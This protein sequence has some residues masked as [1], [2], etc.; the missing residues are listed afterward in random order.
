MYLCVEALGAVLCGGGGVKRC[1]SCAD[2]D[3]DVSD[4]GGV[5]DLLSDDTA[6]PGGG[7]VVRVLVGGV[8]RAARPP[9]GGVTRKGEGVARFGVCKLSKALKLDMVTIG[10]MAGPKLG[11]WKCVAV[12][13]RP[14][15]PMGCGLSVPTGLYELQKCRP[16]MGMMGVRCASGLGR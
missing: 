3:D 10:D 2:F 16:D 8:R 6:R 14:G 11:N 15:V 13:D 5:R 12:F 1:L 7:G 9:G 4:G